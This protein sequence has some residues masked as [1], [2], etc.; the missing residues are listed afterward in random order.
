MNRQIIV[1]LA[2]VVLSLAP[3]AA[4]SATKIIIGHSTINPRIAPLW[5]AQEKG[6]FQKYGIDATLVFVRN[7]PIMIAGMKSGTI[8]IAYGGGSGILGASVTESDLRV[9][10]T[11]T[12]KMTNNVVAKPAIKTPKELRGKI[13][14]IQGL[15][16]TNWM[17]ALLW[18]EHF[19]LDL[20]RDNIMLQGT[21]EQ[22][23]RSQA[24]ESGLVDAAV[25][26]MAFSK[27]L[28][29]RG[30]NILGDSQ[31]TD[32]PFTGVDI[33]TTRGLI[34][35]QPNLIENLLKALLES[36]AFLVAPRNQGAVVELIMKK[37]RIK[38]TVTAEEGYQDTVR[39]MARKPYPAI[40]GMR[41]VQRL[42]KTQN[43]RIAEVNV[44]DLVDS[45]FIR[46]L[47]DSGF[48]ERLYGAPGR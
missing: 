29:Q 24:L 22:V 16:G 5:I 17:A 42:L 10:A 13:L 8:P 27:K 18:L 41:N 37:L 2:L 38:D 45:R 40:E 26:D 39:T 20:R 4:P 47:D 12:G 43:P 14:G 9:L 1:I 33:V 3:S 31:K 46:K 15:G 6:Y 19:G 7:T 23:V 32:I 25:I 30:F 48:F 28:E 21:G 35:E 44:E 36:L 11:F 34:A